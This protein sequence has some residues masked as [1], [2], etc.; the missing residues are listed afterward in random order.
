[1]VVAP[2]VKVK[3]ERGKK[4]CI[5]ACGKHINMDSI[6]YDDMA[7]A[8]PGVTFNPDNIEELQNKYLEGLNQDQGTK[9]ES[10]KIAATKTNKS[11]SKTE[12]ATTKTG[13]AEKT[14]TKKRGRQSFASLGLKTYYENRL[15]A[16][17]EK[18][19]SSF[20]PDIIEKYTPDSIENNHDI[21]M[22]AY[23]TTIYNVLDSFLAENPDIKK[24]PQKYWVNKFYV[25]VKTSIPK[26]D[27]HD[28][29]LIDY[30]YDIYSNICFNLGI[31]PSINGYCIFSG[32]D[33]YIIKSWVENK[34]GL[35]PKYAQFL[36]KVLGQTENNLVNKLMQHDGANTNVMFLL[37]TCYGY[38]K[39]TV[40]S[41]VS[42][43][44]TLKKLDDI[45]V[46]EIESND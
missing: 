20:P 15:E 34:E 11:E 26:I 4:A 17:R 8:F 45:P 9:T 37:N 23:K 7:A 3:T 25:R 5:F 2:W 42:S 21:L 32:V 36:Q 43:A 41:H 29:D 12:K 14:G 18:N 27:L 19:N 33:Y 28:I 31:L 13:S 30:I 10:K 16:K 22:D 35:N 39:K 44:E 1:M 6:N 40:V 24:E 46:F 38:D